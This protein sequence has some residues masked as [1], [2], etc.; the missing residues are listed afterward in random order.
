MTQ[1][2][3]Q[4][5]KELRERTGVGMGKC[6]EALTEAGGDINK[7]IA[8][9]RKEGLA[10]AVKKESR[11]TNEGLIQLYE[12]EGQIA[13]VQVNAETDFVVKNERFQEFALNVAKEVCLTAPATVDAFLQ[14][15]Y[16][17]DSNLTMDE[18]RSLTIQ[19]LGENIQISR[20]EIFP[21]KAN[22]SIAVYSHMGGKLVT[23]IEISGSDD[24][25][26]LA[27]DIAMHVAAESPEYIRS[28]EV[29]QRVIDHER[30]IARAQMKGKPENM[31]EKILTG[32]LQSYFNQVCLLNQKY[33]KNPDLTIQQLLDQQ[34]KE[35]GKS[36]TVSQFL[37]WG[38]GQ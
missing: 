12:N 17:Q 2:T 6:K 18:Y 24:A 19:A 28:D 29:P 15:K 4:M 27:K 5:L 21:K 35:M 16:S 36:L 25:I 31:I 13:L 38:V 33:V 10:S 11:E 22:H 1:I 34:G 9:L 37:R 26:A 23:L 32:K 8:N 7:A 14:Q 30:D 20:F 3:A